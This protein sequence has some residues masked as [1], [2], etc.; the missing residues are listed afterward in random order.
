MTTSPATATTTAAAMTCPYLDTIQRT[1]LDFDFEVACSVTLQTGPHIYACCVC[2]RY[3]R[4]RGRATPAYTHAVDAS[5][6]VFLH[7]QQQTFYCL[8][9]NYEIH[10]AS[11]DDIRNAL[12]PT[13]TA[14][15]VAQ[16]D[17]KTA[18]SRD[19][20]GRLYR[21]GF[22]GLNNLRK[23]DGINSVVQALAHV[24][25]LRDYFLLSTSMEPHEINSNSS[26]TT[27]AAL[28][29]TNCFAA[30]V[31]QLWSN[32]RFKSQVDPHQLVQAITV[33]SRNKYRIGQQLEV[34][35]FMAWF[36]H[37][38]HLGTIMEDTNEARG[39]KP[40]G[41]RKRQKGT[42]TQSVIQRI[43]QGKVR[44]TTR[45][46]KRTTKPSSRDENEP[47]DRAGSDND[48][49]DAQIPLPNLDGTPNDSNPSTTNGAKASLVEESIVDTNFL[50]LTLDLSEKPLFRDQ[51]GGLVIP[52]EPLVT[53]LQKFDGVTVSDTLG[54]SGGGGG[55]DG[56]L[57][58]QRRTY[59]LL[60]LPDV[61]ILHVA[62]FP[63]QPTATASSNDAATQRG[64]KNP[65][66]VVFP[67]KNLNLSSY[68]AA[69]TAP[70]TT[71]TT[72]SS[73]D[74][75]YKYDLVA[76]VVHDSPAD[77]GREGTARDALQEGSYKCHVQHRAGHQQWYE[78]QDLHVQE[79][80]PQQIGVSESYLLILER[81]KATK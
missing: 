8:P 30:L 62:R 37:Q 46:A 74:E 77:V 13:Y 3:F 1:A 75:M 55:G 64:A 45:Q 23:T 52:Q 43:F 34:G 38:L 48:D 36:L 67:V 25:P 49:V 2:G 44:V 66:I 73:S 58:P 16:L 18:L 40:P 12:H 50:Q 51:D 17:T 68:V 70:N 56:R 24:R 4:G 19:L 10:D 33:A 57:V 61:L 6:Y 29:V 15:D 7:L 72:T 60:Q 79:I 20:F 28:Q 81:T 27:S 80:M 53:V 26:S 31:R 11:L 47:D 35:E 69:T 39:T 63:K 42:A 54:R 5:H 71:T 14:P 9:D 65:T 76:N 32:Q 59:Q 21:P 22:V 78:I 41:K